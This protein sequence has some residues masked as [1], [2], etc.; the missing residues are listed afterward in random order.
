M[1]DDNWFRHSLMA[2]VAG[3][4]WFFAAEIM[5][6]FGID[7]ISPDMYLTY[8]SPLTRLWLLQ[9]TVY[10]VAVAVAG[11]VCVRLFLVAAP[12]AV[13]GEL[14]PAAALAGTLRVMVMMDTDFSLHPWWFEG[15]R[16]ALVA[17][18][19]LLFAV[20]MLRRRPG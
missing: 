16:I 7:R 14:L 12:Q 11:I 19:P 15:I 13:I 18:L 9:L 4:V 2:M 20:W 17:F 3:L 5:F 1:S 8:P 10:F 6:R